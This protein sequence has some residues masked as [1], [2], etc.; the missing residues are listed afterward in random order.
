[1]QLRNFDIS[2]V[3]AVKKGVYYMQQMETKSSSVGGCSIRWNG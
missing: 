3:T 1:M 2:Q